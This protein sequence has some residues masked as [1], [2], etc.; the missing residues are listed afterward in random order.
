MVPERAAPKYATFSSGDA[1]STKANESNEFGL[2]TFASTHVRFCCALGSTRFR[3]ALWRRC[4][5]C[6]LNFAEFCVLNICFISTAPAV[7]SVEPCAQPN[8]SQCERAVSVWYDSK[9]RSAGT[10]LF[11]EYV[12]LWHKV[13]KS[14]SAISVAPPLRSILWLAYIKDAETRDWS[15]WNTVQI[16]EKATIYVS[17]S[18]RSGPFERMRVLHQFCIGEG[19]PF[20]VTANSWHFQQSQRHF[21]YIAF[22]KAVGKRNLGDKKWC[23]LLPH[24]RKKIARTRKFLRAYLFSVLFLHRGRHFLGQYSCHMCRTLK[25]AFHFPTALKFEFFDRAESHILG[26]VNG[27]CKI[28]GDWVQHMTWY[29]ETTIS[30]AR[31]IHSWLFFTARPGR[32]KHFFSSDNSYK[33]PT[34]GIKKEFPIRVEDEC[35]QNILHP[36]VEWYLCTLQNLKI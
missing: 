13:H 3:S 27:E 10:Q 28:S 8:P 25:D 21:S 24:A 18:S 7:P 19:T 34:P 35:I 12:V 14:I 15:V 32:A 26:R 5:L 9:V 11:I 17:A 2:I 16:N 1:D 36:A 33:N 29:H 22:F 20:S 31:S 30:W 23:K 6:I 4:I